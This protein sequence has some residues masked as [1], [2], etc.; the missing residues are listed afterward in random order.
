MPSAPKLARLRGV[1]RRVGVGA[2]RELAVLVRPGHELV[3]KS[4]DI[5]G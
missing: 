2:H 5:S 1:L 4:P 3:T